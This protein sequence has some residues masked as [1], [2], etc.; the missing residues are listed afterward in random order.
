MD[1]LQHLR[2]AVFVKLDYSWH[3]SLLLVVVR[4]A[5]RRRLASDSHSNG[6]LSRLLYGTV[7]RFGVLIPVVAVMAAAQ[8][9]D[10]VE[11]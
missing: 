8:V 10:E 4:A 7:S 3:R 11:T 1:D 2:A 9:T 6:T 5:S